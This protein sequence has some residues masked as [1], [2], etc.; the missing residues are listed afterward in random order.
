MPSS[1]AIVTEVTPSLGILPF[2]WTPES[3]MTPTAT[4]TP[5]PT[6]VGI[7]AVAILEGGHPR[8]WKLTFVSPDSAI[9]PL[10][11]NLPVV[12]SF[13]YSVY[14]LI[15]SP[16]GRKLA[17]LSLRRNGDVYQVLNLSTGEILTTP[18]LPDDGLDSWKDYEWQLSEYPAW[19]P[20]GQILMLPA[21]Y[22]HV[23]PEPV[24][25]PFDHVI[26][27]VFRWDIKGFT[28]SDA[29]GAV[30]M[31]LTLNQNISDMTPAWSPDGHSLAFIRTINKCFYVAC[32]RTSGSVMLVDIQ[33]GATRLLAKEQVF[34]LSQNNSLTWSPDGRWIAFHNGQD[35]PR[36]GVINV[37]TG[38]IL[39]PAG[40]L[41]G[42]SPAWAPDGRRLA[43]V[44]NMHDPEQYVYDGQMEIIGPTDIFCV[45]LNG[46]N[47]V[48]LTNNPSNRGGPKW[49]LS[50]NWF[51][52]TEI[53]L[54]QGAVL[55]MMKAN[56]GFVSFSK[57]ILL[58]N[59]PPTWVWLEI[60]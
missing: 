47:L 10:P 20:D 54:S 6:P 5:T 22:R 52:Y 26:N 45:N 11:A 21:I 16:D 40:D 34:L 24:S 19:S 3:L 12:D 31:T 30:S 53:S 46:S 18:L 41:Y 39:Y 27:M 58:Q 32:E 15:G 33:T 48:N 14:N 59:V 8:D 38:E 60:K 7:E 42:I 57:E 25:N 9:L 55:R 29:T 44:A 51:A 23:D 2:T 37:E 1:V 17:F 13:K 56:G 28:L 4:G 35:Y 50:G 49:S 43:F 36:I